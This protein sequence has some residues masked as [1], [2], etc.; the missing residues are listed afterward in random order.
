[1]CFIMFPFIATVVKFILGQGFEKKKKKKSY[2]EVAWRVS[3]FFW[4]FDEESLLSVQAPVW[5]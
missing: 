3:D 2:R 4:A 1:M 5:K